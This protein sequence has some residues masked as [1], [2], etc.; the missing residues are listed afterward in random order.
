MTAPRPSAGTN[1]GPASGQNR[2]A[3][4]CTNRR[5]STKMWTLAEHIPRSGALQNESLQ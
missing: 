2:T 1:K 4:T 5:S 3:Q